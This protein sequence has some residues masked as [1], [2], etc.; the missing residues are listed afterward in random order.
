MCPWGW[1][2]AAHLHRR[3][4]LNSEV[5]LG[6]RVITISGEAGSGK[7]TLL[8]ELHGIL[9]ESGWRVISIGAKFREFCGQ[10]GLSVD[11]IDQLPDE[12]HQQF[13]EFQAEMLKDMESI[14]LESRL[15]GYWARQLGLADVLKVFCSLPLE[16]RI[17]RIAERQSISREA[18]RRLVQER[19]R[20]DQD[21]YRRLYGIED[22]RDPHN[23]DLH[24]VMNRRP[25][26]LALDVM[27][28]MRHDD[29]LTPSASTLD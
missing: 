16:N 19:D 27:A 6:T 13:D 2:A 9:G 18:A 7:T 11:E 5:V 29:R 20:K 26:L 22:Y 17:A 21:R 25:H 24:L 23:Y 28:A 10:R 15:A 12:L 1:L 14:L 3:I 8:A 4:L